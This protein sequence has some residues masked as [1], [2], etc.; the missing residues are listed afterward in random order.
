ME[1][2]EALVTAELELKYAG[3]FARERGQ[4]DKLR[5]MGGF[6]LP[7]QR[8]AFAALIASKNSSA[9]SSQS[10]LRVRSAFRQP[11]HTPSASSATPGRLSG[12]MQRLQ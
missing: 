8:F 11:A 7:M 6:A 9:R 3:Y 1:A 12:R 4:A 2:D 5:K 10:M